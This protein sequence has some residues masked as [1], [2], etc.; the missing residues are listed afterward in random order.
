MAGS[1]ET[2]LRETARK[3][4]VFLDGKKADDVKIL[5]VFKNTVIADYFIIATAQSP[6]HLK[7]LCDETEL[8]FAQNGDL[9]PLRKEES[10]SW[11][12]IDYGSIIVHVFIPEARKN[13]KLEKLWADAE[14][15]DFQKLPE[16]RE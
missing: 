12:L 11:S 8:F 15:I 16:E 10:D 5:Y 6:T 14:E 4:A 2:A 3:I 13:Y 9:V 1:A 7:A